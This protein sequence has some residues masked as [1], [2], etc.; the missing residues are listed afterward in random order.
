MDIQLLHEKATELRNRV[1]N[2]NLCFGCWQIRESLRPLTLFATFSSARAS[3]TFLVCEPCYAKGAPDCR[4]MLEL[5]CK[6]SD[7]DDAEESRKDQLDE[8]LLRDVVLMVYHREEYTR[9][10]AGKDVIQ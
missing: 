10:L 5:V 4:E 9:S 8:E 1:A 6:Y 7:P 3:C 2:A